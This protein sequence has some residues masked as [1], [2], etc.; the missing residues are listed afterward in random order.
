MKQLTE[1]D[2]LEYEEFKKELDK[3]VEY[4]NERTK[5]YDFEN[6]EDYDDVIEKS[7]IEYYRSGN[8]SLV[9]DG[10]EY[11]EENLEIN[12]YKYAIHR[13]TDDHYKVR[14]DDT[15]PR[16]HLIFIESPGDKFRATITT[17]TRVKLR[18]Y[19]FKR[20]TGKN[21]NFIPCFFIDEIEQPRTSKYLYEITNIYEYDPWK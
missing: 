8:R 2:L 4:L 15:L 9:F 13:N 10:M 20:L 19:V 21:N 1:K 7:I 14:R 16:E 18:H 11:Y 12:P 17:L 5:R 6:E 3:F